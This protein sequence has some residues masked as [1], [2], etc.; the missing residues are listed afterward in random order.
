MSGSSHASGSS[1]RLRFLGDEGATWRSADEAVGMNNFA[2]EKAGQRALKK[3][4]QVAEQE[5]E[6]G[7]AKL[8]AQGRRA[9]EILPDEWRVAGAENAFTAFASEVDRRSRV[10]ERAAERL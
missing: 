9:S 10:N 4:R 3:L 8:T 1:S 6:Q 7:L 5:N 2:A